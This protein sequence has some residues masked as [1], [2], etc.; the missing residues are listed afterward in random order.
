MAKLLHWREKLEGNA[1]I[2]EATEDGFPALVSTGAM[3]YLAGWPDDEALDRILLADCEKI[4]LDTDI[5][6]EGL[7]RR[8]T[9]THRF[10]FNY[11]PV[12]IEWGNTIIPAAGVI[13]EPL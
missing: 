3:N 8:D 4:G 12:D 6:P 7:R 9:P 11:N 1:S 2:T 13:W 5:M 10:W